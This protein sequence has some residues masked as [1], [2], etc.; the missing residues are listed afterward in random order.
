MECI[1]SVSHEHIQLSQLPT[2]KKTMECITSVSHEHIQFSQLPTYKTIF[3]QPCRYTRSSSLVTFVRSQT[4]TY[5]REKKNNSAFSTL[6]TLSHTVNNTKLDNGGPDNEER[7][8]RLQQLITQSIF[9]RHKGQY[10]NFLS[11][12]QQF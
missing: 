8:S 3:V 9:N 2:Y 1:T 7:I 11:K 12:Q 10:S 5:L 6:T 4:C